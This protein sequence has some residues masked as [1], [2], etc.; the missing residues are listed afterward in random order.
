MRRAAV[1]LMM[2]TVALA[3]CSQPPA[4]DGSG[5]EDARV[6]ELPKWKKGETWTIEISKPGFEDETID[7][8]Y[9]WEKDNFT[10]TRG[11]VHYMLG[12]THDHAVFHAIFD[13]NPF[14]GRI[15]SD[16][17]APHEDGT[18]S[19]Q[20]RFPLTPPEKTWEE[21]AGQ[22]YFG[23]HRTF[24]AT[25]SESVPSPDGP[26]EGYEIVAEADDGSVVEYNYVPE[27][28]WWTELTVRDADGNTQV[29]LTLK[30]HGFH[31]SGVKHFIRSRVL[32]TVDDTMGTTVESRTETFELEYD[33]EDRSAY[34]TFDLVA[35][36]IRIAPQGD[37]GQ[38]DM[39]VYDPDGEERWSGTVSSDQGNTNTV[40]EIQPQG[41]APK[42]GTWEIEFDVVESAEVHV[43][44]VAGWE[45][46]GQGGQPVDCP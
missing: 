45:Y 40:A 41:D 38:V 21:R 4:D 10:E 14:L 39:T 42:E 16:V 19:S 23:K 34:G 25:Y 1:A 7:L 26:T 32:G 2:V 46:C 29:D 11:W 13:V 5:A 12:G 3:G 9:A 27:V 44:A 24:T 30:D 31:G 15:H 37:L 35:L 33:P 8:V 6:M 28:K 43:E 20:Y 17:L 22:V 18:H 36:G